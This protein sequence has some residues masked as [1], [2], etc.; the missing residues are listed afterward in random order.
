MVQ[1]RLAT[2]EDS[3]AWDRYLDKFPDIPPMNRYAWKG[4]LED[5]YR[6]KTYFF[7]ALDKDNKVAGILSS[8]VT[9]DIKN[10]LNLYSLRFGIVAD[11]K[12]CYAGLL[13]HIKDFCGQNNIVSN[14]T[15]SGY[16]KI[17]TNYTETV[18]KTVI[19]KLP[20]TEEEM[21]QSLRDKTRNMIRK[22]QKSGLVAERGFCGLKE[23][24]D[25][26]TVNML[27]KGIPIHRLEFFENIA[28]AMPYNATLIT[29][30]KGAKVIGGTFVLHSMTSAI[31]PF[32]SSA[33]DMRTY[34]PNPFLVW[35]AVKMCM[36]RGI[37]ALDMGESSQGGSVYD[38]KVN[39]GGVP[40]D[41]YYYTTFLRNEEQSKSGGVWK[42]KP[43]LAVRALTVTPFFMR[44]Q[45]GLWLKTRGR[46][47]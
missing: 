10:R 38:F 42:A 29:A 19:L 13:D 34:A 26:Y 20:R 8:Y 32:Q 4:I 35:E 23:F 28:G 3:A 27:K 36:E 47:I 5:T 11:D 6:V 9:R 7:I 17:D 18:K 31:Y 37:P 14:L 45:I 2:Q 12:A 44:K 16:K 30:K 15:A 22:S 40:R 1:V 33:S 24:Y 39:F 21:W 43:S 41:V 46:I 25:I